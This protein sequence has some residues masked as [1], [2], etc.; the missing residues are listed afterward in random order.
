MIIKTQ[1]EKGKMPMF[2]WP[3]PYFDQ[4]FPDKDKGWVSIAKAI[5]SPGWSLLNLYLSIDA[6]IN[7]IIKMATHYKQKLKE[8]QNLDFLTSNLKLII[9]QYFYF[10]DLGLT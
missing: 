7:R 10:H 4:D 9:L 1:D 2:D 8:W 5:I 6:L 3:L